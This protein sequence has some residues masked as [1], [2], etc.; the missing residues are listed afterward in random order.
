MLV[1]LTK[2]NI[3]HFLIA[4]LALVEV[5]LQKKQLTASF[6]EHLKEKREIQYASISIFII[7]HLVERSGSCYY[8]LFVHFFVFWN[9]NKT[10]H[11]ISVTW[12]KTKITLQEVRMRGK[13]QGVS[14]AYHREPHSISYHSCCMSALQGYVQGALRSK[15]LMASLVEQFK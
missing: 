7:Q 2:E 3:L 15:Q 8:F 9:I 13:L 11:A 1:N 6:V 14:T 10:K 12:N 4:I 5:A